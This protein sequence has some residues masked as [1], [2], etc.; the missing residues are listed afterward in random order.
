MLCYNEKKGCQNT[1]TVL[2]DRFYN[3]NKKIAPLLS[4]RRYFLV[5]NLSLPA[6]KYINIPIDT[7]Y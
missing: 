2:D 6:S 5:S 4:Q 1:Q 7:L 3:P